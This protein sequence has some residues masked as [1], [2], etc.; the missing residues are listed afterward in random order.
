ME[1]TSH[2]LTR[3]GL[4]ALLVILAGFLAYASALTGD[5]TNWDDNW[6]ITGN[7]WIREASWEN[8][9]T[10]LDPTVDPEIRY[11]LG[12]EYLPV[13]DLSYLLDHALFGL[14]PAGFHATNVALHLLVSVL[15]YLL[16]WRLSKNVLLALASALLFAVHPLHVES[17]AWLS[18]RKDLLAGVFYLAGL[19][20]WNRFRRAGGPATGWPWF[21]AT[22]ACYVLASTSKYMAIT[23]PAAL[24]L[25]DWL[26]FR[27][28]PAGWKRRLL[29]PLA[30]TAPFFLFTGLFAR[31]V[32]LEIA[33]R[34]LIRDWYGGSAWATLLTVFNVMREYVVAIFLPQNLQACVDH[35]VTTSPDAPTILSALFLAALAGFGIWVLARAVLRERDAGP[36][37]RLGAFAVLFFFVA[38]SPVSNVLFPMGTLYAD[39]YLYLPLA[40]GPLVLGGLFAWAMQR[41]WRTPASRRRILAGGAVGALVLIVASFGLKTF[42][43]SRVWRDSEALWTDVLGKAGE[44]HHTAHFNLGIHA[45]ERA[46]KA[47]PSGSRAILAE[48][49]GHLEKALETRHES[50]FYDYARVHAAIGHVL[51]LGGETD[52]AIRSYDRALE[53]NETNIE[54]APTEYTRAGERLSRASI[55]NHRGSA[56]EKKGDPASLGKAEADFRKAIELDPGSAL[57]HMNLGLLLARRGKMEMEAGPFPGKRHIEK[58]MVLDPYLAEAPLNLG[59]LEFNQGKFHAARRYFEMALQRQPALPDARFY[60]A[61]IHLQKEAYAEARVKFHEILDR[62]DL[63]VEWRMKVMGQI[64]LSFELE[65]KTTQALKAYRRILDEFPGAPAEALEPVKAALADLHG[66]LGGAGLRRQDYRDACAWF[67]RGL[68]IQP[69]DPGLVSGLAQACL[70]YGNDILTRALALDSRGERRA[71][72]LL[73]RQAIGLFRRAAGLEPSFEAW[74]AVGETAKKVGELDQVLEAFEKARAIH[75]LPRLR[76]DAMKIHLGKAQAFLEEGNEKKALSE[77]RRASRVEPGAVDPHRIR[78]H[79]FENRADRLLEKARKARREAAEKAGAEKKAL[80]EAAREA[81]ER[82]RDA[83]RSALEAVEKILE[84]KPG[85]PPDL[86]QRGRLQAQLG[87]MAEA[88]ET[89]RLLIE[90]EPKVAEHYV[91]LAV[92]EKNEGRI[93]E[94]L[95]LLWEALRVN[96]DSTRGREILMHLLKKAG[97]HALAAKDRLLREAGGVDEKARPEAFRKI[98]DAA[99]KQGLRAEEMFKAYLARLGPGASDP[100]IESL[101]HIASAD[102]LYLEAS[103]IR[104]E[105]PEKAI[106]LLREALAHRK[107]HPESLR[108]L[109]ELLEGAGEVEEARRKL[110]VY[111][112]VVPDDPDR[113]RLEA[114]RDRLSRQVANRRYDEAVEK[115]KAG[116]FEEAV[117]AFGRALDAQPG[118]PLYLVGRGKAREALGEKEKALEDFRKAAGKIVDA[119]GGRP[120]GFRGLLL[121]QAYL[122]RARILESQERLGDAATVLEK[123]AALTPGDPFVLL[124]LAGA[125]EKAEE[126]DAARHAYARALERLEAWKPETDEELARKAF[127]LRK[128]REG[129]QRLQ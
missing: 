100:D 82:R 96:P 43:Y 122:G 35:P 92:L 70:R 23:L 95:D 17:V 13:R 83:L 108:A 7:P 84:I 60:L 14:R 10:I 25:H 26:L 99:E 53:I 18:S 74:V 72:I 115:A 40:G 37:A 126:K 117:E 64:A 54:T 39:R 112:A 12:G 59:I 44:G 121:Q 102:R 101:L 71:A 125:R 120:K 104:G 91:N 19:L 51:D 87:R 36:K 116:D 41:A 3:H 110:L 61:A 118:A 69:D 58:A 27:P 4:P 103:R 111:L 93:D 98:L 33:S 79:V 114:W 77:C 29:L 2:P 46:A 56:L 107:T 22:F 50:Y 90:A 86:A 62:P 94:A 48:A 16:V 75:D 30:W 42:T 5:F 8:V 38:I 65:G 127:A 113:E 76:E 11:E 123:A 78:V 55:L 15:F 31:F 24:L 73:Y 89:F 6:L 47:G 52:A 66:R 105:E 9:S 63:P 106:G 128:A 129:L 45:T 85:S 67:E 68:A 28:R 80:I 21:A 1:E 32:V 34:G 119:D 88:K 97:I 124:E 20:A 57:A 49:K 109:A 81:R